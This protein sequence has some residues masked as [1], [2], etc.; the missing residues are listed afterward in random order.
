MPSGG[1]Q[2]CTSPDP[3]K[4]RLQREMIG[5]VPWAISNEKYLY[6]TFELGVNCTYITATVIIFYV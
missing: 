5:L 6:E 4:I 2:I 3:W 1:R